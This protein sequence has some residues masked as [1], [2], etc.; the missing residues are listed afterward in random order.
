MAKQNVTSM[1]K[2]SG[3]AGHEDFDR[4]PKPVY[5]EFIWN[6]HA[7]GASVDLP[8]EAMMRFANHVKD[9]ASGARLVMGIRH[10]EALN[11]ANNQEAESVADLEHPL[12]SVN[13]ME[14]LERLAMASLDLLQKESMN[15][16]EWAYKHHTPEGRKEAR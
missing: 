9:V 13:Q 10:Y 8:A 2:A 16:M 15:L 4:A 12:F 1:T 5:Q 14:Q 11:D 3:E 6:H 7:V